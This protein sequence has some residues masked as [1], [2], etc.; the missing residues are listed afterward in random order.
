MVGLGCTAAELVARVAALAVGLEQD[1]AGGRQGLV[2]H[3]ALNLGD[4]PRG[5]RGQRVDVGR[6]EP[7][8]AESLLDDDGR[9]LLRRRVG[10]RVVQP[11]TAT[12][13]APQA[14]RASFAFDGRPAGAVGAT[15]GVTRLAGRLRRAGQ[16]RVLVGVR[17]VEQDPTT[18]QLRIHR[19][20]V[21]QRDRSELGDRGQRGQ[22]AD[23][24]GHQ[25]EGQ[26]PAVASACPRLEPDR[27]V[28]R[29][30]RR[31]GVGAGVEHAER[32]RVLVGDVGLAA[33]GREHHADR[34]LTRERHRLAVGAGQ[35]R[36]VEHDQV[37]GRGPEDEGFAPVRTPGHEARGAGGV[38]RRR[39]GRRG[40]ARVGPDAGRLGI[41]EGRDE[42][43]DVGRVD[44]LEEGGRAIGDLEVEVERAPLRS[45]GLAQVELD[46]VQRRVGTGHG[47]VDPARLGVAFEDRKGRE[48]DRGDRPTT[49]RRIDE[50]AAEL[51]EGAFEGQV[52][53]RLPGEDH[54]DAV[55]PIE[56]AV[57]LGD[58]LVDQR[59]AGEVD[60][61]DPGLV[62]DHRAA[63]HPMRDIE[64]AAR[65]IDRHA[66][67][68]AVERDRLFD[69]KPGVDS[70]QDRDAVADVARHEGPAAIGRDQHVLGISADPLGLAEDLDDRPARAIDDHELVA[71]AGRAQHPLAV[72]RD[73]GGARAAGDVELRDPGVAGR[74]DD[75][76]HVGVG[77]GAPDLGAVGADGQRRGAASSRL[78]LDPGQA[79]RE[80]QRAS[81]GRH[82]DPDQ[83]APGRA[84]G[85]RTNHEA[86]LGDRIRPGIAA[87]IPD[88]EPIE[89]GE[90]ELGAREAL[91]AFG[92]D[93]DLEPDRLGSLGRSL[94]QDGQR[95][96]R[97]AAGDRHGIGPGIDALGLGRGIEIGV[98][99]IEAH[100]EVDRHRH[101][102]GR[103]V[104]LPVGASGV[105]RQAVEAERVAVG[106][107]RVARV[108][109]A[110]LVVAALR[111]VSARRGRKAEQNANQG[112]FR[113]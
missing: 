88:R 54:P 66:D 73:R 59:E 91:L 8:A 17:R 16:L 69:S 111:V 44:A 3:R 22:L 89:A 12:R 85:D 37:V 14:D 87:Q 42:L 56:V 74:V 41:D 45:L 104:W 107:A 98:R 63:R 57:V 19:I 103:L 65:R 47:G 21:D 50:D 48:P 80:R 43:V 53:G 112:R 52:L 93:V 32:G 61:A 76:E 20:A 113:G 110:D 75:R 64:V 18:T 15:M 72:G 40:L 60:D 46:Q 27:R 95:K 97:I 106:V 33:V 24:D 68:S 36:A 38:D 7:G 30:A 77:E 9:E 13:A 58:D 99:G 70:A 23:V 105:D 51:R 49:A 55:G 11:A 1:L 25:R 109:G 2:D 79:D 28:A 4:R 6:R 26:Q 86:R 71:R 29:L 62:V 100:V 31:V 78:R 5:V 108:G 102:T 94:G 96:R 92:Q 81:V 35:G 84:R 67:R 83:R 39:G 90:L 10:A 34:I 101:T 82:L